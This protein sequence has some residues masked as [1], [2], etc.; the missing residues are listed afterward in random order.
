[1][2]LVRVI[3]LVTH[4][5]IVCFTYLLYRIKKEENFFCELITQLATLMV[6]P[7]AIFAQFPPKSSKCEPGQARCLKCASCD[8]TKHNVLKMN[9]P[10]KT[11][12]TPTFELSDR[13]FVKSLHFTLKI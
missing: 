6:Q 5:G 8:S 3:F 2:L 4:P 7:E 10:L 12:C 13:S 9:L 1:M 11:K